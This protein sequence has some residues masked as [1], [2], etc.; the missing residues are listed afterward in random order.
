[1]TCWASFARSFGTTPAPRSEKHVLGILDDEAT[2][3]ILDRNAFARMLVRA[4]MGEIDF[5]RPA[6]ASRHRSLPVGKPTTIK[7]GLSFSPSH[8]KWMRT[9]ARQ[10]GNIPVSALFTRLPIEYCGLDPL[11]LPPGDRSQP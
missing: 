3:R 10:C 8:V 6:S 1:M 5:Q 11:S 4:R 9:M 2:A 7:T